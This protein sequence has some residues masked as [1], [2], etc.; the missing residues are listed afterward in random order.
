MLHCLA[1][2]S[3]LH[4]T[5]GERRIVRVTSSNSRD[6]TGIGG[7]IWEPAITQAPVFRITLFNGDFQAAVS[8]GAAALPIQMATLKNT[9]P[10]ADECAWKGAE[11]EITFDPPWSKD[12]MSEEAKLELGML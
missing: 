5:S 1:T 2:I 11:V 3:P 7:H 4:I 10:W 9:Y 12:L 8:A 6:I